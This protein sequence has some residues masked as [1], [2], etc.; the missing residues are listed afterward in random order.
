V[1]SKKRNQK[2]LQKKKLWFQRPLNWR[3]PS[4]P[5]PKQLSQSR[6]RLR[7]Q[8]VSLPPSSNK[9][10]NWNK[11]WKQFQLQRRQRFRPR[12]MKFHHRSLLISRRLK[13][14]VL[15]ENQPSQKKHLLELNW[16]TPVKLSKKLRSMNSTFLNKLQSQKL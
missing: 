10:R 12:L 11:P 14:W 6:L 7:R 8:R 13:P 5:I 15:K 16:L 1:T 2:L 9:E 3:L 4:K